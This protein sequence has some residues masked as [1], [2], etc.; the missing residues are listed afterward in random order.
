MLFHKFWKAIILL[1]HLLLREQLAFI[2]IFRQIIFCNYIYTPYFR[3]I[4]YYV[5]INLAKE[6]FKFCTDV[7][8]K[9]KQKKIITE[10]KIISSFVIGY[11]IRKSKL[12]SDYFTDQI[13]WRKT[14]FL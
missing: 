4:L 14:Y 3:I 10:N 9:E 8:Q 13:L 7:R 5:N 2:S 6:T 12:T 11:M 1:V